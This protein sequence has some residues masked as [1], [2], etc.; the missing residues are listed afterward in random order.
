[1][2]T[3]ACSM[4]LDKSYPRIYYF[5]ITSR[6]TEVMGHKRVFTSI[7]RVFTSVTPYHH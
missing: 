6:F 2:T 5:T 3:I 4:Q 7:N 1:M